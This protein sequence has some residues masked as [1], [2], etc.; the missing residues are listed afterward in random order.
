MLI[1]IKHLRG[2]FLEQEEIIEGIFFLLWSIVLP[3]L[4]P[5]FLG[6]VELVKINPISIET[7]IDYQVK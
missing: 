2:S 5:Y 4:G 3:L 1:Y 6:F 7:L